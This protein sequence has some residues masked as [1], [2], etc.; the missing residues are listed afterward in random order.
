MDSWP[1]NFSVGAMVGGGGL[2]V[3]GYPADNAVNLKNIVNSIKNILRF[4]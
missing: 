2:M 1:I 3:I 4:I